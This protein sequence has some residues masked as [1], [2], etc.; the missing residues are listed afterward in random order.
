MT[1]SALNTL[2]GLYNSV[3]AMG[4]KAVSSDSAFEIEGYEG[5]W[6]LTKQFPFPVSSSQ[7]EIEIPMP[8]GMNSAQP[9]QAKIYHQGQVTFFETTAGHI[10]GLMLNLLRSGG[11]FNAKIY[12]GTPDSFLKAKRVVDCFLVMDDPDRDWENRA[13]VLTISGTIHYHFFGEEIAGNRL[14]V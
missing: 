4:D 7:G 9:Q 10:S 5:M 13:Q 2:K 3:R 6:L 1:V 12:E 11:R 8:M 14:P